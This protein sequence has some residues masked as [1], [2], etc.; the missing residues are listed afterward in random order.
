MSRVSTYGLADGVP[1]RMNFIV[2]GTEADV[3]RFAADLVDK[4]FKQGV[5]ERYVI[6]IAGIPIVRTGG[7]ISAFCTYF[8]PKAPTGVKR[9]RKCQMQAGRQ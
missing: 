6:E 5:H 7:E 9:P 3:Y 4:A 8:L 1:P 2:P